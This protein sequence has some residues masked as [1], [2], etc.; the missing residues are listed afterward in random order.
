[1]PAIINYL[2]CI[3][4]VLNDLL[5]VNSLVSKTSKALSLT[6]FYQKPKKEEFSG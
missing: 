5:N 2:L 3:P 1:M 6:F 4:I